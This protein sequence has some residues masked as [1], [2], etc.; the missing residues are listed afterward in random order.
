LISQR[1]A[2]LRDLGPQLAEA[3]RKSV[4]AEA[5]PANPELE[6]EYLRLEAHYETLAREVWASPPRSWQDV[7]DR[8]ELAYAYADN[9]LVN[10]LRSDD[11]GTRSAAELLMAVLTIAGPPTWRCWQAGLFQSVADDEGSPD[12]L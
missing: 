6:A 8:A 10:S 9:E 12:T 11:L 1:C 3:F 5:T 7:V 4:E 2:Q